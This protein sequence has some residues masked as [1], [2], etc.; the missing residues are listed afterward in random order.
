M[1][2]D[3]LMA[4]TSMLCDAHLSGKPECW[5]PYLSDTFTFV[6]P[7]ADSACVGLPTFRARC[8][9]YARELQHMRLHCDAPQVAFASDRTVVLLIIAR[10]E[11]LERT[12]P[13][14]R[15]TVVWCRQDG[16]GSKVAHIHASFSRHSHIAYLKTLEGGSETVPGPIPI[17]GTIVRDFDGVSRFINSGEIVFLEAAHQYV[18]FHT[19]SGNYKIRRTL[20]VALKEMGGTLVRVHRSYAVNASMVQSVSAEGVRMVTGDVVPIP[21]KRLAAVR[22]DICRMRGM[23]SPKE[24]PPPRRYNGLRA[25]ARPR[26]VH[27]ATTA[28]NRVTTPATSAASRFIAFLFLPAKGTTCLG[29]IRRSIA[30]G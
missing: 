18:L 29:I 23:R 27:L 5:E 17:E 1:A 6:G 4:T 19:L 21:A 28:Y 8:K 20:S 10:S 13:C 26:R 24:Y 11:S 14:L 12:Q 2:F 9:S 16:S 3:N 30:E 25:S 22:A 15:I 7:L